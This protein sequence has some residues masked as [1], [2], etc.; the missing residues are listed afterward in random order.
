MLKYELLTEGNFNLNSL[1][2]YDRRQDVKKVYR[3]REGKYVMVDAPYT[4][5]WDLDK[6]REVARDIS[7]DDYI[8][9]IALDEGVVVGFIGMMKSLREEYMI[10]DVMQVSAAYRG[11]GIGRRLFDFGKEEARKAGA[12]GLYISACSSE[13]NSIK[14]RGL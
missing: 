11:R 1:D 2:T 4:E 7:G 13:E 5:D 6:K 9:Y 8:T 12:K 3:R 10:L 14:L